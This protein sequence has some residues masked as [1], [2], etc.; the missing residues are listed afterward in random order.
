MDAMNFPP[1]SQAQTDVAAASNRFLSRCGRFNAKACAGCGCGSP[2]AT[3][4]FEPEPNNSKTETFLNG[5][6]AEGAELTVLTGFPNYPGG[7]VYS[8]LPHPSVPT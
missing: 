4:R 3:E 1:R 5:L 7:K 6:I 8:R 2:T